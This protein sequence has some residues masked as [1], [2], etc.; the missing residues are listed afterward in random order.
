VTLT[1]DELALRYQQRARQHYRKNGKETSE[2]SSIMAA[3]RVVVRA[4]GRERARDFGPLKLQAVRADMIAA[5]WQ[6][7]SIN[8][9]I[10]RIRRMFQ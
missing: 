2:V 5:G 6:R 3:L 10:G 7:K 8:I 9:H 4:A 1:V